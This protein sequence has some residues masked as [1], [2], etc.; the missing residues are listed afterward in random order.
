V[1]N[2]D[3]I[4]TGQAAR[5]GV[6]IPDAGSKISTDEYGIQ[7]GKI[8]HHLGDQSRAQAVRP[9]KGSAYTGALPQ[10]SGFLVNESGDIKGLEGAAAAIETEYCQL[11][12]RFIIL[13]DRTN[14][15][16]Y[17]DLNLNNAISLP[18]AAIAHPVVTY[19]FSDKKPQDKLNAIDFPPN[20][21]KIDTL[22]FP[23]R[24]VDVVAGKQATVSVRF[25]PDSA[26]WRCMKDDALPLCGGKLFRIDQQWKRFMWITGYDIGPITDFTPGST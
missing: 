23:F 1:A 18:N 22:K 9:V 21:P 7:R 15:I 10:F 12:P 17:R 3:P 4:R 25:E 26:G 24:I 13:P 16:E 20:A 2:G 14:D 6:L 8:R 19:K 5:S 11:D